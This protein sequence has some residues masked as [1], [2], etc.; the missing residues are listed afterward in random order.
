MGVSGTKMPKQHPFLWVAFF[1]LLLP[2]M[3]N[4]AKKILIVDSD[5]AFRESLLTFL[6][7]L[8]HEVFEAATGPDALDKAF[9]T[10][11]DLILMDVRLPGMSGDDVTKRL[12]TNMS[13]RNI[14]VVINSGWTTACNVEER[15]SRALLAGAAEVLYKPFQ[16]ATLRGVLRSYLF[17]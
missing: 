4:T 8:G 9:N 7:G 14:P 12:K 15:I 6:K 16:F 11:P 3:E 10:R 13:T 1:V 2:S 17:A 5:N